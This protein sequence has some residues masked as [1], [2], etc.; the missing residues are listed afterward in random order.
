MKQVG[1]P[2]KV[3]ELGLVNAPVFSLALASAFKNCEGYFSIL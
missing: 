3:A 2:E 1:H